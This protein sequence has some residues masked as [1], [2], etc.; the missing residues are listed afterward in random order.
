MDKETVQDLTVDVCSYGLNQIL[1]GSG[2]ILKGMYV[3]H[4]LEK[5]NKAIEVPQISTRPKVSLKKKIRVMWFDNPQDN[6][7][8][9]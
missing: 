3:A 2:T 6:Y 7:D 4:K 5:L 1:P 9:Y 8:Q